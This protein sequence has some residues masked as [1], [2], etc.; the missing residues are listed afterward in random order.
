MSAEGIH[1]YQN[2]RHPLKNETYAKRKY[3]TINFTHLTQSVSDSIYFYQSVSLP[4]SSSHSFLFPSSSLSFHNILLHCSAS[5][6]SLWKK[7][8]N[9]HRLNVAESKYGNQIAPPSTIF[10]RQP[11]KSKTKFVVKYIYLPLP[12]SLENYTLDQ[13]WKRLNQKLGHVG[14][15]SKIFQHSVTVRHT[16]SFRLRWM[17]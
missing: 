7:M 11:L 10:D 2:L 3:F 9:L 1:F 8:G 13:K 15:K 17:T 4:S 6:S 16:S 5:T 12:E 14:G